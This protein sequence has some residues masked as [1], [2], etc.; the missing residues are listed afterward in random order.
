MNVVRLLVD[1][2][3]LV[4]AA[5][6]FQCS[7]MLCNRSGANNHFVYLLPLLAPL[8]RHLFKVQLE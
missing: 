1:V 4:Q 7:S 3:I 5:C 6:L 2:F 8:G